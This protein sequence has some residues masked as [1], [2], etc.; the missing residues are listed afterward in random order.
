MT[1]VFSDVHSMTLSTAHQ[2]LLGQPQ[3]APQ[4]LIANQAGLASPSTM[5]VQHLLIPVS[6]GNGTQ[7]L[8]SIPLSLAAGLGNQM[9][10]LATSNGQLIATNM[11]GLAPQLNLTIPTSSE[12]SFE[13]SEFCFTFIIYLR[14]MFLFFVCLSLFSS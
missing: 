3:V 12:D 9:Q 13:N 5:P 8:V 11:A 14:R 4:F 2:Q 6:T 10:L 1:H 7:Q